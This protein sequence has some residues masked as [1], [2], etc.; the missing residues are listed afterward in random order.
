MRTKET[1]IQKLN[2]IMSIN[3]RL[4]IIMQ[5]QFYYVR[6]TIQSVAGVTYMDHFDFEERYRDVSECDPMYWHPLHL[7]SHC[8]N[9]FMKLITSRIAKEFPVR[10]VARKE[11]GLMY[12]LSNF[13]YSQPIYQIDTDVSDEYEKSQ[14]PFRQVLHLL[15]ND[16]QKQPIVPKMEVLP[17]LGLSA[18]YNQPISSKSEALMKAI[19]DTYAKYTKSDYEYYLGKIEIRKGPENENNGYRNNIKPSDLEELKKFVIETSGQHRPLHIKKKM[20]NGDTII[21]TKKEINSF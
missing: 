13:G 4:L 21:I 15:Q 8:M 20:K 14:S 18:V 12:G 16:V 5:L 2:M 7:P 11:D 6:F 3:Y 19:A 17:Y 1:D 10:I 9:M